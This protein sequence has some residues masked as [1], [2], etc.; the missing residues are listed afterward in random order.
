MDQKHTNRR[1][2]YLFYPTYNDM[3]KNEKDKPW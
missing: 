1:L 3:E 2:L